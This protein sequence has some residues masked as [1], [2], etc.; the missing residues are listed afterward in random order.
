MATCTLVADRMK[1]NNAIV[2]DWDRGR[3]TSVPATIDN[4]N[5]TFTTDDF[6]VTVSHFWHDANGRLWSSLIRRHQSA[7]GK[8]DWPGCFQPEEAILW[9]DNQDPHDGP[10]RIKFQ[11]PVSAA[12]AQIQI[13]GQ[14][15]FTGILTIYNSTGQVVGEFSQLCKSSSAGD[16]SATFLGVE[17]TD[18]GCIEFSTQDMHPTGFAINRLSVVR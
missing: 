12:G 14:G 10:I 5:C 8:P 2:F 15:S 3:K 9:T 13:L 6:A 16:D 1:L 17:G 4:R 7:P 11:E 18:I